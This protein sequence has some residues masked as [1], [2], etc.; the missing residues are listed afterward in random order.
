MLPL[1]CDP[2]AERMQRILDQTALRN[3]I[4]A[5]GKKL[6]DPSLAINGRLVL[7]RRQAELGDLRD[8]RAK[9]ARR[10]TERR[11]HTP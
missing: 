10:A 9:L 1:E 6:A 2:Y 5:V 4:G 3:E 7:L 11:S 8:A